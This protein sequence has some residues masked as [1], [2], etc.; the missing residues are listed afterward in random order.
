MVFENY[1]VLNQKKCHYMC[2]GRNTENDKFEFDNL[3]LQNSNKEVV[4]VV[5]IDNK[6]IFGVT[7][8]TFVGRADKNLV[9]CWK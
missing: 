9:H 6:L 8:R 3:L 4:L 2:R 5:T 1:M 7:L